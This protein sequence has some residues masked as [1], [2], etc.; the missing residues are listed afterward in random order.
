MFSKLIYFRHKYPQLFIQKESD[1][2]NNV[3]K[4]RIKWKDVCS[5]FKEK[6]NNNTSSQTLGKN[7]RER[8]INYLNPNLNR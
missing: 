1:A 2:T 7:C 6:T 8:W 4:L 5:A 3:P